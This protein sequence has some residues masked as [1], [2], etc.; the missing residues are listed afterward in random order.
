MD[1]Q[2]FATAYALCTSVGLR[3]FMTLAIASLAVHL[4]YLH[5]SSSFAWMG[6]NG[7]TELLIGLA[8]VEFAIEKFP[9][10]DHLAHALHFATKP[11]AAAILVGTVV[12]GQGGTPDSITYALMVAGALNALGVHSASAGTRAI[13]TAT[14]AGLGNPVVSLA[15]D[16]LAFCTAVGAILIPLAAAAVAIVVTVVALYVTSKLWRSRR[17]LTS[18][19]TA[20]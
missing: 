18:G 19:R 14:T 16:V 12:P 13:S 15:E 11:V 5:P 4:G 2:Q 8:V 17:R 7:V 3:A 6:A 20:P 10:V 9:V 1:A